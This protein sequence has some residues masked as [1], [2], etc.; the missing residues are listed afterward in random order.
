MSI[1]PL[2]IARDDGHLETMTVD[3]RVI[4]YQDVGSGPTLILAHCSGASHRV[5]SP[6]VERFRNQYRVMA[7]DLV[8]YGQ[9]DPWPINA[10]LHPW[11]DL[12]AIITL[13]ERSNEPVHLV[14][15]SYGGVV[16]LEAARVLGPRVK[17][18]TLIEP[19]A[20]HLLRLTG[21]MQE[22]QELSDVGREVMEALRLRRERGAAGVYM[23]Y[24]VGRLRWW[25]MSSKA[26]RRVLLT[27]GKV[28]AEFEAVSGLSTTA[29]D[30]RTINAPTRL[31]A[32]ERTRK[33]ARALVAELLE[34]LPYSHR[35]VIPGA[36]HMSPLTHPD[37][38]ANHISR[39]VEH[40][41]ASLG[42]MK[43]TTWQAVQARPRQRS[44]A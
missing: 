32:G 23:K 4:A 14:G 8:G 27:V 41:E 19:V 39:H 38:V 20:F 37:S 2:K 25:S 1:V 35:H 40:V 7:P 43:P 21:R 9:S 12:S 29:G 30:Y 10:R 31:V 16:A 13:A 26:R 44:I 36:G 3:G 17:S 15:H 24:W 42:R 34:L 18:L 22:W 11:S 6:F 5:W 33:P 28:G